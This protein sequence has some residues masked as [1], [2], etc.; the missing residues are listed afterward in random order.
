MEK[1]IWSDSTSYP[2]PLGF[3]PISINTD[4]GTSE[5]RTRYAGDTNHYVS[6]ISGGTP[7][8]DTENS[9]VQRSNN[10]NRIIRCGL[11]QPF[12]SIQDHLPTMEFPGKLSELTL[13]PLRPASNLASTTVLPA[14]RDIIPFPQGRKLSTQRVDEDAMAIRPI[15]NRASL[16]SGPNNV[17]MQD[18]QYSRP[19]LAVTGPSKKRTPLP[20][21]RPLE[22]EQNGRKHWRSDPE[23]ETETDA[24]V[25]PAKRICQRHLP[26]T[27]D[28]DLSLEENRDTKPPYTYVHLAKSAILSNP[29]GVLS[30]NDIYAF[31]SCHFAYYRFLPETTAWQKSIRHALRTSKAFQKV[32]LKTSWASMWEVKAEYRGKVTRKAPNDQLQVQLIRPGS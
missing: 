10:C 17:E 32:G 15:L 6:S 28:T 1:R 24:E 16:S 30:L 12:I 20:I 25:R 19:L 8:F 2:Q 29:E 9:E 31:I 5:K 7:N 3:I 21:S 26:P 11:R 4:T 13:A 27:I 23:A 14:L 22:S 18:A